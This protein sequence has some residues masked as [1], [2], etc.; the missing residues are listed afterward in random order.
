MTEVLL[1]KICLRELTTRNI[2]AAYALAWSPPTPNGK[3]C[4]GKLLIKNKEPFRASDNKKH[5][6]NRR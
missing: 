3:S 6:S 4:S 2:H 5:L 1:I